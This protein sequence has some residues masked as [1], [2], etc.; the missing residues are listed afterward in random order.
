MENK[1]FLSQQSKQKWNK[2]KIGIFTA[3]IL[4]QYF[5]L[6]SILLFSKSYL[7]IESTWPTAKCRRIKS[8]NSWY[9]IVTCAMLCVSFSS[10]SKAINVF[11]KHS[12]IKSMWPIKSS[13]EKI[14]L[15][16][17]S[18]NYLSNVWWKFDQNSK[19]V[20]MQNQRTGNASWLHHTVVR[21]SEA[22]TR[23]AVSENN[24]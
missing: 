9:Y 1:W 8:F 2:I 22:A 19:H 17:D 13:K 20:E 5:C 15:S 11:P 10:K 4:L 14:V 6:H 21:L 23:G 7:E 12:E 18:K 3:M 16:C 24:S